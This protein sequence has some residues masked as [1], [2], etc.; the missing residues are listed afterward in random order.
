MFIIELLQFCGKSRKKPNKIAGRKFLYEILI[1][2]L[3]QFWG[4]VAKIEQ[5]LEEE[6]SCMKFLLTNYY[7]S[8]AKAGKKPHEIATNDSGTSSPKFSDLLSK[9]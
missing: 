2:E 4:K 8:V 5:N 1:I 7:S 3:L 9:P 6:S